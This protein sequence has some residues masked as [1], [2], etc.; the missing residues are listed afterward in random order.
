MTSSPLNKF[1]AHAL[2]QLEDYMWAHLDQAHDAHLAKAMH[3]SLAAGGKRLRPL[4]L[5]ATATGLGASLDAAIPAA[6]AIEFIHTYSLIHDDLP[7]MDNAAMRRGQPAN[8]VQFDEAT[9]ILAGDALLTDAFALVSATDVSAEQQ[10]AL[11]R[12]LATSAG[13]Q[14]MVAGQQLDLDG[15]HLQLTTDQLNELNAH[16]T[17]ALIRAAVDMG[18]VIG[19]ANAATRATL[20]QF[21]GAFGLGFQLLDDIEDVTMSAAQLGKPAHQDAANGKNTYV[22]LLGLAGARNLLQ[23][24]AD[25]AQAALLQ[26]DMQTD[27]LRAIAQYLE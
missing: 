10:V 2:P 4:L 21:A 24:Q 9:A 7:A 5:L 25:A 6:A 1:A 27:V 26:L 11:V 20:A 23:Q 15:S 3:Y 18:A 16:K 14:G 12:I 22:A 17:G 19:A 13:S 8:H